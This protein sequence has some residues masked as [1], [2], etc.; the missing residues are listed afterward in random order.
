MAEQNLAALVDAGARDTAH[1]LIDNFI[2]PDHKVLNIESFLS[3]LVQALKNA[4]AQGQA[5]RSGEIE[6]H[7]I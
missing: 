4:R 1:A 7:I 3:A 5:D 6:D 2:G